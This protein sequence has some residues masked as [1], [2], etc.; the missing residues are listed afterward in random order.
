MRRPNFI[1]YMPDELRAD[2]VHCV[3]GQ[4][5]RTP[6]MD[7]LAAEGAVF[8]QHYT[9][10]TVCSPSRCA[11]MTGWYPHV[12]GHRTLQ[13]L[14]QPQEPNM[15]K[16]LKRAGYHVEWHG[17]NDL[18]AVESFPESVSFRCALRQLPGEPRGPGLDHTGVPTGI[19]G[20]PR[21]PDRAGHGIPWPP[22]HRYYRTFYYG[23]RG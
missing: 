1:F 22:D 6:H 10:N 16:Y 18:L 8:A 2:S 12:R 20:E 13:H 11:L 21:R 4:P 7:R 5:V 9:T 19:R 17:K 14:L 3:D 23:S 15:L